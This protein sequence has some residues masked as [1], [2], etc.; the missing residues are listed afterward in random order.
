MPRLER[1]SAA[2]GSA[3]GSRPERRAK[4]PIYALAADSLPQAGVPQ[5][6]VTKHAWRASGIYPG[7]DHD[8]WVYVPAQYAA[9]ASGEPACVM[10]F[11]DGYGYL[12]PQGS[13]RAPTVFDNLIHQGAMPVTIG[14]FVNPGSKAQEGD[15]RHRQYTPRTD[16]YVRF[17][18]EEILP[19]VGRQYRLADHAAG[20]AICGWSD[21]GLA[22]FTAAWERPQAFAKVASHVG[23]FTRLPG[24]GEYPSLVRNTRGSPKPIRVYVQDGENDVDLTEG[25]W[26]LAN[27]AMAAALRFARYDHRFELGAGGHDMDHGGAVFPDALRWL[28]RDHPGVLGADQLAPAEAVAGVWD[29]ET[30]VLGEVRRS[31]LDIRASGPALDAT[32]VDEVDGAIDLDAFAFE[33][34]VLR[35]EYAPPP[36]QARWGKGLGGTM[37]A[38]LQVR[39]DRLEGALSSRSLPVMDYAARGR[40]RGA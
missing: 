4:D 2:G 8:Y 7:T 24:G 1:A 35:Y 6:R 13:V 37:E 20:R 28:W 38:W 25:N 16:A 34:G 26:T 11:Q 19:Q 5:G 39:G 18:L 21:G 3:P 33:D 32:L 9:L 31:V 36:S 29:V 17:L 40:R 15:Q 12:S 22:A 14:V 30:N 10:V 27:L 23:S